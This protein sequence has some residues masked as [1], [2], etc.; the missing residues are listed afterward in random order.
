MTPSAD[1]T[2]AVISGTPA[3][4]GCTSFQLQITD[5]VGGKSCNPAIT[6]SCQATTFNMVVLPASLAVQLPVYSFSYDGLP[7]PPISL[8]ASGGTPPYTWFPDPAGQATLAPGLNLVASRSS[9]NF[10]EISGTPNVGDSGQYNS[11][12]APNPGQYPT[13]VYVSDSQSP[14]PAEGFA[15]LNMQDYLPPTPCS[16][17]TSSPLSLVPTGTSGNGG[18]LSGGNVL[19][20]SYL[21]GTYAFM[22]RGF[23]AGQ[24]TVIA[25]SMTLDGNGNVTSGEEDFTQGANSSQGVA[26]TSGTYTVG[27]APNNAGSAPSYSRGC[28]T[29]T[30]SAGTLTFD[31]S[32]GGCTNSY[33]EGGVLATNDNACGMTQNGQGENQAAGLFSAGRMVEANDGTGHSAQISGILRAQ[34]TSSFATGLSGP[35][36]FG[37]GGWDASGGHYSMAGSAQI[38]SGNSPSVAADIDDAGQL[39]TQLTGG[40]VTVGTADANGRMATTLS[41]GQANFNLALYMIGPS[42]ALMV[43]TGPLSAS[44]PSLTGLALTTSSSFTNTSLINSHMLA[45]G[46]LA[47]AGPDVSIG[48][49]TF[50]VGTLTGTI[51]ED[52]AGTLGTTAVSAQYTVDPSTGRAPFTALQTGQNLGSHAFVAYLIPPSASLTHTNCVYEEA[53]VT[54]FVVGSDSTAQDGVLEFQVP[55]NGPPPPFT[56]RYLAGDFA[57]GTMENLDQTSASFEGDVYA[58]PSSSNTTG[59]SLGAFPFAF[60][61]DSSYGCL[62]SL[63]PTF[64]PAETFTGSYS[65]SA[66]G[67]GTFGGGAVVSF[68]NGNVTF[69]IDESPVNT[70][71][72]VVVA[73]Q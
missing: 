29:V 24:P 47:S 13:R 69:Y 59:G 53:C 70:H 2:S 51:Y 61:Q 73:E 8:Q 27:I 57:Y 28:V 55:T 34:N 43:T 11:V 7:Y 54:G 62:Q 68:S 39:G 41:V 26:I 10:V 30:S 48:L 19:A 21:Q 6:T 60:Y 38:G 66:S 25:G 45:M 22:L 42:E 15:T 18:V 63:C 1:T 71:P 40:A 12:G 56:N 23:D 16:S 9:S 65:I 64:I 58:D 46:G 49:L 17:S 36:A 32:V 14:Y 3:S 52:Q 35:Y 33:S 4:V 31:F 67:A 20:D 72:S 5:A 50:S 44:N 37:L